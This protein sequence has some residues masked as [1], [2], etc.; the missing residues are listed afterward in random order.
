MANFY[1][2][3]SYEQFGKGYIG[4]RKCNCEPELDTSY[5]GSYRDKTFKPTEKVILETFESY[6]LALEAEIQ[7]HQFFQVKPNHL[8]RDLC[9]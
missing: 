6:E 9:K 5:F 3:Y 1:V 7:L 2:Y 8:N 4:V